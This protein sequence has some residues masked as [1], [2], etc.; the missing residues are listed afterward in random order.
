LYLKAYKDIEC[1]LSLPVDQR[2]EAEAMLADL[3]GL[4]ERVSET[5]PPLPRTVIEF[6]KEKFKDTKIHTDI[7]ANGLDEIVVYSGPLA[8]PL[9]PQ[10]PAATSTPRPEIKI[11][12]ETPAAIRSVLPKI[13]AV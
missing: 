10:T 1:Q 3:R 13:I 5:A 4:L 9:V 6:Y 12:V 7:Q 8:R 11:R 2:K